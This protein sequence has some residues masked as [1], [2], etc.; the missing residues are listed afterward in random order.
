MSFDGIQEIFQSLLA[1]AKLPVVNHKTTFDRADIDRGL[2]FL[3]LQGIIDPPR[4]SA[5]KTVAACQ[6]AGIQVKMIAGDHIA[7]A[8]ALREAGTGN[9]EQ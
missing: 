6:N 1:F 2:I 9:R 5:T 8:I 3:G 7:T 4:A